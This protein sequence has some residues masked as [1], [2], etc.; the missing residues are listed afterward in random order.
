M[1]SFNLS[2]TE[3]SF[4]MTTLILHLGLRGIKPTNF[5]NNMLRQSKP[6]ARLLSSNS[7]LFSFLCKT[8]FKP[9][10]YPLCSS[11]CNSQ[12]FVDTAAQALCS[13][14]I[15]GGPW[16]IKCACLVFLQL[17]W[18]EATEIQPTARVSLRRQ[19]ASDVGSTTIAAAVKIIWMRMALIYYPS[20]GLHT[21]LGTWKEIT[22]VPLLTEG[23]MIEEDATEREVKRVKIEGG[24]RG[25][26]TS[27]IAWSRLPF[28]KSQ[29]DFPNHCIVSVPPD[30]CMHILANTATQTHT[31]LSSKYKMQKFSNT[32]SWETTST[33]SFFLITLNWFCRLVHRLM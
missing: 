32:L 23:G 21:E 2:L 24:R 30:V 17:G 15:R 4:K 25:K 22:C 12:Y 14:N 10:R 3:V 27:K 28:P 6:T 13:Q 7:P 18:S 31:P 19:E 9:P 1:T 16:R 33:K 29:S 11:E 8:W 5:N 20:W 26:R